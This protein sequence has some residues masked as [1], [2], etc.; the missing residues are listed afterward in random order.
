MTAPRKI[1]GMVQAKKTP[2]EL[3]QPQ[4]TIR[5][6]KDEGNKRIQI[7][8]P[9]GDTKAEIYRE[10]MKFGKIEYL[11]FLPSSRGKKNDDQSNRRGQGYIAFLCYQTSQ[12]A[13]DAQWQGAIQY[14]SMGVNA[15][16]IENYAGKQ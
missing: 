5:E 11:Y 8:V 10:F 16:K 1:R 9:Y 2:K 13:R 4:D 3:L 7:L 6:V 12:S 14:G 15:E